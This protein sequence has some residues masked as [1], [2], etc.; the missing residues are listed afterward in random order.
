MWDDVG[1]RKMEAG[2]VVDLGMISTGLDSSSSTGT[3]A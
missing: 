2:S 3:V 1:L